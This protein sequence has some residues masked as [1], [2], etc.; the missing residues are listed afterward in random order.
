MNFEGNVWGAIIAIAMLVNTWMTIRNGRKSDEIHKV[1]NSQ[2]TAERIARNE[3]ESKLV[4]AT[5]RA[6]RAEGVLEG[7]AITTT[8]G[9]TQ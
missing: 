4:A 1:I 8:K 2:L 3:Q 5:D 7:A 9:V 6:S